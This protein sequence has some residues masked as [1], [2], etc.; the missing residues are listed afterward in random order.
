MRPQH[1]PYFSKK[2]ESIPL[3]LFDKI[4]INPPKRS[5]AEVSKY[6]IIE[7][8]MIPIFELSKGDVP[9]VVNVPHAGQLSN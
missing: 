1:N 2:L 5:Y 6:K 7:A 9:L 4:Y 8:A 3:I